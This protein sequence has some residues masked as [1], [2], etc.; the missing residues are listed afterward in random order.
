MSGAQKFG[1][2]PIERLP[3]YE[4]IGPK[5]FEMKSEVCGDDGRVKGV[6]GLTRML[7]GHVLLGG[8]RCG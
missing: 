6:M 3:D 2:R 7:P 4:C 5:M 8:G 1:N